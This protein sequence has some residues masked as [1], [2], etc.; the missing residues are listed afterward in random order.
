MVRVNERIKPKH[1][2]S[3]SA[4]VYLQN[5]IDLIDQSLGSTPSFDLQSNEPNPI[6]QDFFEKYYVKFDEQGILSDP[7]SECE[8]Q[9]LNYILN[10]NVT[11]P[12]VLRG[13]AG[14][15]KS[16][17][18][19]YICFYLYFKQPY[20]MKHLLPVYIPLSEETSK[21]DRIALSSEL[22]SLLNEELLNATF[23]TLYRF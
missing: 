11:R 13:H 18:L 19:K 23:P 9:I 10:P 3:T 22:F 6:I 15:G 2:T 7:L 8:A 1:Q 16:T 4:S 21:I 5:I 12:Y 20:I 17:L 14:V